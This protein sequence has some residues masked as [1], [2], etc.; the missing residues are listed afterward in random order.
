MARKCLVRKILRAG[1]LYSFMSMVLA[2]KDGNWFLMQNPTI[3]KYSTSNALSDGFAKYIIPNKKP[4]LIAELLLSL[5]KKPD[6]QLYG[7][8]N[9]TYYAMIPAR[10]RCSD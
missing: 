5:C 8:R 7:K 9:V 4:S 10:F 1:M 3:M 2:N 6:K